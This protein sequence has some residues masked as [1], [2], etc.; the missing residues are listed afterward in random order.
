M[1]SI[2]ASLQ[3]ER[4][5]F[6]PE[7]PQGNDS[8]IKIYFQNTIFDAKFEDPE[9][10]VVSLSKNNYNGIMSFKTSLFISNPLFC[11]AETNDFLR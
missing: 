9:Q 10:N 11:L 6:S 8:G 5:K 2:I 7:F 4:I 3:K 1:D